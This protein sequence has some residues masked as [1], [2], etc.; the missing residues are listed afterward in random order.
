MSN[1]WLLGLDN[2]HLLID[3]IYRNSIVIFDYHYEIH[4]SANHFHNNYIHTHH[5]QAQPAA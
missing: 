1:H 2:L 4:F 5:F 3:L